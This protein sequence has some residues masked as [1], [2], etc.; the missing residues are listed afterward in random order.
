MLVRMSLGSTD[1]SLP[2]IVSVIK[3][4]KKDVIVWKWS[5]ITACIKTT[6][7]VWNFISRLE[8]VDNMVKLL[9]ICCDNT[10]S[11]F[12]A[13]TTSISIVQSIWTLST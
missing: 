4:K 8:F 1:A 10:A 7:H 2:C 13:R 3:K 11:I 12:L 9:K 6:S 5:I